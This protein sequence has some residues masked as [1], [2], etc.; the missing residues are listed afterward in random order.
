MKFTE[1]KK[2]LSDITDNI[3]LIEGDDAYFRNGAVDLLKNAFVTQPELNFSS[4]EGEY[5]LSNCGEFVS[6]LTAY[7]FMSEKRMVLVKEF[8]PKAD[9]IEKHLAVY[10][11][12]PLIETLFVI[13]NSK[14]SDVLKKQPNIC[15]VDCD[16]ADIDILCRWIVAETSKNGIRMISM[17]AE[18]LVEYC[19]RDMTKISNE[20]R[21]LIDYAKPKGVITEEDVN[22]L[23]SKDTEY[24]IYEM[25]DF[26]GKKR[27]DQA[28][29]TIKDMTAKGEPPQRLIISIYNYF[30]RLLHVALSDLDNAELAKVLG[31]KEYA[32]KKTREQAKAFK[33][34]SLKTAVDFLTNC[35]FN[36][37]AGKT[38]FED[39][40]STALF[41][42]LI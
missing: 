34:K 38:S 23:V 11:Q 16:K 32:V 28:L 36:A 42:I 31:I 30:R 8:Y 17:D 40:L 10:F 24:Q 29:N 2:N 14:N 1:L 20:T 9:F 35:D 26:I 12:N 41:E 15:F 5:V 27:Y 19:L 6:A 33:K 21:K 18:K 7:P 25:T 39:A 13:T 3:F 37:K 22:L 4:Y